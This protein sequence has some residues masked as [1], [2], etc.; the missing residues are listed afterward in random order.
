M[1]YF[2]SYAWMIS[3]GSYSNDFNFRL[4]KKILFEKKK[5]FPNVFEL[6]RVEKPRTLP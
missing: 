5:R 6:E 2:Y 1:S 3:F 4:S